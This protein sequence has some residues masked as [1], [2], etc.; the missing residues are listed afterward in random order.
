MRF[1][2]KR[3]ALAA[4]AY[5]ETLAGTLRAPRS[6]AMYCDVAVIVF[7]S[8]IVI[9]VVVIP[10]PCGDKITARKSSIEVVEGFVSE[11]T[12]LDF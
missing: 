7:L 12:R 5:L 4:S 10:S 1:A 8:K 3:W 11:T 6:L 9:V 2:L